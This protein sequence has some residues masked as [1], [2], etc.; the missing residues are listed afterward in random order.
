M[1]VLY[2]IGR[3]ICLRLHGFIALNINETIKQ[4][5]KLQLSLVVKD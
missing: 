4:T 2:A 5:K 1:H 3:K